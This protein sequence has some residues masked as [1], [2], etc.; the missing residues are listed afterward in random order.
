[1]FV[2][3]YPCDD[4]ESAIAFSAFGPQPT[5]AL[6]YRGRLPRVEEEKEVADERD[7]GLSSSGL[8]CPRSHPEHPFGEPSME[9]S[10]RRS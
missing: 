1:M 10:C 5:T 8:R 9:I 4:L 3:A 2:E 6:M 7:R